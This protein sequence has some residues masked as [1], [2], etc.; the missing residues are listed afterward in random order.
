MCTTVSD[1]TREAKRGANRRQQ[2]PERHPSNVNKLTK[3][4]RPPERTYGNSSDL[5]ALVLVCLLAS[6][7]VFSNKSDFPEPGGD[8]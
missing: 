1:I 6:T 2:T 8:G 5:N 7:I 3:P 4:T